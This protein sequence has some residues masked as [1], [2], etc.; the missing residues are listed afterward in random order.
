MGGVLSK[1]DQVKIMV[2]DRWKGW[3]EGLEKEC[4]HADD[5]GIESIGGVVFVQEVVIVLPAALL[6]KHLILLEIGFLAMDC[7]FL[8]RGTC[9]G[10]TFVVLLD[11][12]SGFK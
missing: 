9:F 3:K 11:W 4:S 8:F 6:L 5:S 2:I 7:T 12:C 1:E 10:V